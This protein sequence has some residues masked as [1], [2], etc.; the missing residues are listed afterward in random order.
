M[1]QTYPRLLRAEDNICSLNAFDPQE[2]ELKDIIHQRLNKPCEFDANTACWVYTGCCT[3]LGQRI[4]RVRQA[5]YNLVR[6]SAWIY[7][8]VFHLQHS[9]LPFR[10]CPPP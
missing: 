5:K 10:T 8:A 3:R 7:I 1:G 2:Q 4:I 9:R 6:A